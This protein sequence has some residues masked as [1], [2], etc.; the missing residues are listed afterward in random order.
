ME[1]IIGNLDSA[2]GKFALASVEE[3]Y[4][5][6]ATNLLDRWIRHGLPRDR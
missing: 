6:T 4:E 2:I 1:C 3:Q 5:P